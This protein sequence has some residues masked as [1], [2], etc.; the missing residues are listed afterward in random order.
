MVVADIQE[1]D[2]T[3]NLRKGFRQEKNESGFRK[4]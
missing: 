4:S 3:E 1:I 2:E